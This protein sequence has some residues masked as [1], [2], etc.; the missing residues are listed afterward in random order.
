MGLKQSK[1]AL[2]EVIP[3][4]I[5]ITFR[6]ASFWSRSKKIKNP[7]WEL[8]AENTVNT[9]PGSYGDFFENVQNQF[10]VHEFPM[11]LPNLG[12]FPEIRKMTL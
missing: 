9:G 2:P 6:R 5:C 8:Q 4:R 3:P 12:D 11:I 10:Y 1:K 7:V